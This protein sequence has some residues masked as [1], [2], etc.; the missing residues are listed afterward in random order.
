[1]NITVN[2]K[3]LSVPEHTSLQGALNLAGIDT[4]D[5]ATALNGEVVSLTDRDSTILKEGDTVLVIE[6]FY[7]G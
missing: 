3:P 7:G 4:T 6:P 5:I 2:N 1:M